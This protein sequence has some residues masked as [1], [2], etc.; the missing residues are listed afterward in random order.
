MEQTIVL[1]D[2]IKVTKPYNILE[3]IS[4]SPLNE[5]TATV[6]GE[7]HL[8]YICGPISTSEFGRHIAILGSLELAKEYNFEDQHYCLAIGANVKRHH[9]GDYTSDQ[10]YVKAKISNKGR[11]NATVHG[12]MF[13][14]NHNLIFSAFIDYQILNAPMFKKFFGKHYVE[15]PAKLEESP[16]R[17]RKHLT[18]IAFNGHES[19]AEY[20]KVDAAYCEGHFD[21]YPALPVA[22]VGGLFTELGGQFFHYLSENKYTKCYSKTAELKALRLVFTGEELHLK[23]KL[24]EY[25]NETY[26]MRIEAYVKEELVA[27]TTCAFTGYQEGINN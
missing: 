9:S 27:Y 4:I 20:G 17:N 6:K 5:V 22:V 13:D 19:T 14:E 12:E 16:Y 25:K 10:F 26:K 1:E 15:S 23:A 18:N 21:N 24:I 8:P 2:L 11:R 3:N 7:Y